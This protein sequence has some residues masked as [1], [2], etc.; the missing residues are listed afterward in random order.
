MGT[1]LGHSSVRWDENWW[2]DLTEGWKQVVPAMAGNRYGPSAL[3]PALDPASL[4]LLA[5]HL[6][7]TRGSQIVPLISTWKRASSAGPPT[8]AAGVAW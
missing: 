6:A 2:L 4:T 3:P 5:D 8:T 1:A 7:G